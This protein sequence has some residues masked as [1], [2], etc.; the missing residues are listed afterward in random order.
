M[1][2]SLKHFCLMIYEIL[3]I[4][5]TS[6]NYDDFQNKSYAFDLVLNLLNDNY[7]RIDEEKIYVDEL[8]YKKNV[9]ASLINYIHSIL[10]GYTLIFCLFLKHLKK[11]MNKLF[12]F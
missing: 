1:Q 9:W 8:L 10:P 5:S 3:F 12:D 7:S 2:Y 6:I 4:D 11:K